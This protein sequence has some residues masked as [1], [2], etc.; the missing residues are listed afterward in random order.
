MTGEPGSG[1]SLQRRAAWAP[2]LVVLGAL[3]ACDGAGPQSRVSNSEDAGTGDATPATLL[4]ETDVEAPEVFQ[5][6]DQG[7]WDGRPSLGGIWVAHPDVTAP[8]RVVIR[9]Q[10]NDQFVIG[11]L[12]RRERD[13][14]GPPIQVSSD[15]AEA[16]GMLA[17]APATLDVTALRRE[18][19]AEPAPEALPTEA[20]PAGEPGL[21]LDAAADGEPLDPASAEAVARAT[22]TILDPVAAEGSSDA[23]LDAS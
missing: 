3:A 15:A 10:D 2:V 17:G 1:W 13:N 16:L 22:A 21:P 12:F 14:P 9:N 8:E 6:T 23:H 5:V 19:P 7:L 18:D 11:A 20:A 4:V